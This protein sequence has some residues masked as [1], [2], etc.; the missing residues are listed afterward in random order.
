M[1]VILYAAKEISF[2]IHADKSFISRHHIT[3]SVDPLDMTQKD[4]PVLFAWKSSVN[5]KPLLN[6]FIAK[7]FAGSEMDIVWDLEY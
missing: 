1:S 4:T 6:D 2:H 7:G 5:T 3:L